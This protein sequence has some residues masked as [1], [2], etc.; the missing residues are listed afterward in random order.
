MF[1]P[2]TEPSDAEISAM[3]GF[4]DPT[5]AEEEPATTP[6]DG[7]GEQPEETP[8]E[9]AA[10]ASEDAPEPLEEG[11]EGEEDDGEE[12]EAEESA[13]KV[14]RTVPYSK[15]KDER[16]KRKAAET[17]V[18]EQV[19]MVNAIR[20]LTDAVASLKAGTDPN[21]TPAEKK[22]EIEEESNRLAEELGLDGSNLTKEEL[23]KVLRS[24]V[25][26]A[27][28]QIDGKLP[29]DVA[30]KLKL[31]DQYEKQQKLDAATKR[32]DKE[33]SAALP[34][35]QK[36]FPNATASMLEEAKEKLDKLAH[37]KTYSTYAL[38]DIIASPANRQTFETILKAAAGTRSGET[39]KDVTIGDEI[40]DD[41]EKMINIEDMT[42]EVMRA[43]EAQDARLNQ[44][45]GDSHKDYTIINPIDR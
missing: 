24:A 6:E 8:D 5:P 36:I 20:S 37:S 16:T 44:A 25:T 41:P 39:G 4:G 21:Q 2:N 22:D 45:A 17:K 42:P 38:L 31:V 27:G 43:R 32:F 26:L 18:A 14:E 34:E 28:K 7:A 40:D 15:H 12:G 29:E 9:P 13:G 35:V 11:A 23:A 10:P 19:E 30:D 1:E 33:W 3:T